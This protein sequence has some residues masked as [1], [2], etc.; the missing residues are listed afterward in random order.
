MTVRKIVERRRD[1]ELYPEDLNNVP[2]FY[3][4]TVYFFRNFL[5]P[6]Q[7]KMVSRHLGSTNLGI[8]RRVARNDRFPVD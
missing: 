4:I 8:T 6:M 5:L 7:Y 1:F 3:S 2:I